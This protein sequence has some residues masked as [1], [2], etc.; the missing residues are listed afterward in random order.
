[1][2]SE[3]GDHH[4]GQPQLQPRRDGACASVVHDRRHLRVR[5]RGRGRGRGRARAR[6]RARG[7]G[8]G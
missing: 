6:A 7:R 8:Y 3:E 2:I 4:G 5:G 1:M